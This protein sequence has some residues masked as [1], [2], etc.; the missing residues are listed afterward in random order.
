MRIRPRRTY[1][2]PIE[3]FCQGIIIDP[4]TDCWI[5]VKHT[6]EGYG[7]LRVDG[8]LVRA[9]RFAY[10]YFRDPVPEGFELDHT[11]RNRACANPWHQEPVRHDE[12]LKRS[13]IQISAINARKMYCKRGHKFTAENTYRTKDGNRECRTCKLLLQRMWRR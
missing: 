12:N 4:L 1:P 10:E 13:P 7:E 3:R 9:H 8:R 11:C 2:P 5:W 6:S